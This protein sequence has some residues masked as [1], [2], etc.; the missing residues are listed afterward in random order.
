M[1]AQPGPGG[2]NMMAALPPDIVNKVL[3]DVTKNISNT[4]SMQANEAIQAGVPF[5]NVISDLMKMAAPAMPQNLRGAVPMMSGGGNGQPPNPIGGEGGGKPPQ[6]PQ[7]QPKQDAQVAPLSQDSSNVGPLLAQGQQGP[8]ANVGYPQYSNPSV[9]KTGGPFDPGA[10]DA[11]TNTIRMPGAFMSGWGMDRIAKQQEI[12]GMKPIQ[13]TTQLEQATELTKA[14]GQAVLDREKAN[15][16]MY[17]KAYDKLV[18][19]LTSAKELSQVESA[20]T[21][22]DNITSLL[23]IGKDENGNVS[24]ANAGLLKDARWMSKNRQ[25]LLRARDLYI[26]KVLRRDSGATITP[27]DEKI[28]GKSIGFNVGASAFLQNPNIV[29]KAIMENR[30]Q[31]IRDRQ[32][33]SPNS[34]TRKFIQD[35]KAAGASDAEIKAYL[36]KKGDLG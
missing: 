3:K 30:D 19:P 11:S 27:Q 10:F 7:M 25:E 36:A 1:L 26:N 14:G 31:L 9:A 16:E 23:G 6:G 22:I 20:L 33:L 5:G 18:E 28:A 13:P 32:N 35:A 29:A 8:S 24:V 2:S 21:G 12:L 15:T 4:V 17:N 34:A